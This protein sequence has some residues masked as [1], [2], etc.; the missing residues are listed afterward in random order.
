MCCQSAPC[1]GSAVFGRVWV[2][3]GRHPQRITVGIA[4]QVPY[5]D[6]HRV[7]VVCAARLGHLG[8]VFRGEGFNNLPPNERH[9]VNITSLAFKAPDKLL[10]STGVPAQVVGML[11]AIS[12]VR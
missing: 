4:P 11:Y 7:E 12:C 8:H 1:F 5:Q 9:C 6:G 2:L 10:A 3:T